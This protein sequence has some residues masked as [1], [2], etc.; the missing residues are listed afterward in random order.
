MSTFAD[1]RKTRRKWRT[2]VHW[3]GCGGVS[4]CIA[5][6]CVHAHTPRNRRAH[7]HIR[8]VRVHV[9]RHRSSWVNAAIEG[10]WKSFTERARIYT[11]FW[12]VILMKPDRSYVPCAYTY[13][14]CV[15][16]LT[17]THTWI[18]LCALRMHIHGLLMCLAYTHAWVVQCTLHIFLQK[19]WPSLGD[20]PRTCARI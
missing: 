6:Q 17:H 19:I 15:I 18:V 9:R 20:T 4:A 14:G 12:S 11:L 13:M 5:W 16:C 3:R 10:K 2:H 1:P 7:V 8:I